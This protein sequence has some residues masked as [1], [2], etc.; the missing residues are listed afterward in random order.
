MQK[1]LRLNLLSMRC[2]EQ[3]IW[4][5]MV[6]TKNVTVDPNETLSVHRSNVPHILNKHSGDNQEDTL[7]IPIKAIHKLHSKDILSLVMVIPISL[8]IHNHNILNLINILKCRN[9]PKLHN[10][11]N[12]IHSGPQT[13][14]SSLNVHKILS[15]LASL[16]DMMQSCLTI[17]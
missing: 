2:I 7:S 1:R 3:K 12:P 17:G 13:H 4:K 11:H 9:T 14:N 10:T 8:L 6:K 16:A 15:R 5:R